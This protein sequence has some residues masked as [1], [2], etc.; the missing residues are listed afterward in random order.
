LMGGRLEVQTELGSGSTFALILPYRLAE[1]TPPVCLDPLATDEN[2]FAAF[3]PLKIMVAEDDAINRKLVCRVLEKL[4]Y[5][6]V[7]ATDGNEAVKVFQEERPDCILMDLKMPGLDGL[8]ATR[9]VRE[10]ERL[11]N[12]DHP[13]F[14]CAL[15][16][17]VFPEDRTQCLEAGMNAFLT[18]PLRQGNL[19]DVLKQAEKSRYLLSADE[20]SS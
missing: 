5:K 11:D 2:Q 14:I 16:A 12:E 18:K 7:L 9:Q 17:N 10:L 13:V 6:P 1:W 8:E 3:H 19:L 4:G 15:T 20:S